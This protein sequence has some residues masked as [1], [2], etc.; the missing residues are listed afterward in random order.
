MPALGP[1]ALAFTSSIPEEEVLD[2]LSI[3]EEDADEQPTL[4]LNSNVDQV[5]EPLTS[6]TAP[7]T[8][9]DG[10]DKR[11]NPWRGKSMYPVLLEGGAFVDAG[12][13]GVIVG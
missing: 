2:I 5:D 9:K 10:S 1:D 13:Q 3:K 4:E 12:W 8:T 7:P 6:V 11:E